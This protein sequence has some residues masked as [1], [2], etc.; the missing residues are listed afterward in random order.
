MEVSEQLCCKLNV[1]IYLQRYSPGY[2]LQQTYAEK[3]GKIYM[4]IYAMAPF[5][6]S[7]RFQAFSLEH[8]LMA[9]SML[10]NN[11]IICDTLIIIFEE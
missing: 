7:V 6:F 4:K 9:A 1:N 5:P 2:V 11:A 3:V 8:L 10:C